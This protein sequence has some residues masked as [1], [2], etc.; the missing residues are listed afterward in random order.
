MTKSVIVGILKGRR[1]MTEL[2]PEKSFLR[3]RDIS[4]RRGLP[5]PQLLA[6]G[7][8]PDEALREFYKKYGA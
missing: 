1:V 8:T 4:Q 7:E 6:M 2:W 5:E 3:E